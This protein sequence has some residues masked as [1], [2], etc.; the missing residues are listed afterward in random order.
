MPPDE[1]SSRRPGEDC[2]LQ[3]HPS[4]P[5]PFGNVLSSTDGE[6]ESQISHRVLL[7][8][9]GQR[10]IAVAALREMLVRHHASP[11]M[12]RR[13]ELEFEALRRLG[14][15]VGQRPLHRFPTNPSTRKGNLAEVVL[16]EYVVAASSLT[17][18]VYRLRYNPNVD[19]SMKGD[20]VLAFDL[21]ADPVRIIVGEA[22]FRGSSSAAAVR[23][24]VDGLLRSYKAGVPV[25]L[26]FVADRLF[27]EGQTES[28]ARV[29][30][31]ALLFAK[32]RLRLDY[33]GLLLSDPRSAEQVIRNTPNSLRHLAMISL[34]VENPDSLAA[35]CYETLE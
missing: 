29:M 32:D 35:A 12:L 6:T 8:K 30:K 14:F 17:L 13:T 20:D 18:P 9:E 7:E 27:E 24:I 34:G 1:L 21:D 26:Q 3:E 10:S 15:D 33:V 23:E 5:H 25:S 11:E 16:A 2:I 19:Q 22:K 4:S 28:G 31:C